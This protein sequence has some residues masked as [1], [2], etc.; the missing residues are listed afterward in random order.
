MKKIYASVGKSVTSHLKDLLTKMGGTPKAGDSTSV[1]IDKIED[2]YGGSGGNGS[3]VLHLV[4]YEDPTYGS[5]TR[6][7]KTVREIIDALKNKKNVYL[8]YGE[9][10]PSQVITAKDGT[11]TIFHCS[12]AIEISKIYKAPWSIDGQPV[13][14]YCMAPAF[15]ANAALENIANMNWD[16]K[17]YY[18]PQAEDF[19]AFDD[20]D[21]YM[22]A[23]DQRS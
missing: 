4:R 8:S 10:E 11:N 14:L 7:D 15:S 21:G 22:F 1:L 20:L 16:A 13:Q 3:L 17:K 9:R 12:S 23:P 6:V 5:S 2:V 19:A 18:S